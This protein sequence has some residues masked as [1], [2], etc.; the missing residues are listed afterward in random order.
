MPRGA[1]RDDLDAIAE[2][3]GTASLYRFDPQLMAMPAAIDPARKFRMDPDGFGLATLLDDILG[4][5]PQRFLALRRDFCE[6]FPQFGAVR[7]ETEEAQVRHFNPTGK[8]QTSTGVGKGISFETVR[9]RAI[10][11]QQASDGA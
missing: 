6:F 2:R 8:H 10:R 3:L 4:Y 11:A 1:G 7:I 5:D 9:G